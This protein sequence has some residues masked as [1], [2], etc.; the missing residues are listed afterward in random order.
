MTRSTL[1]ALLATLALAAPAPATEIHARG[2]L[3]MALSSGDEAR[4]TTHWTQ[5]D[6]PYDPYRVHLF[7]DA[8]V[9]PTLDLFVQTILHEGAMR[10]TADGAYAQWT[11]WPGRDAHLQAGKVPWPIGTWGAREYSDRN[12]L[13]GTP[14]MYQYHSALAWDVPASSV[15]Q[16]LANAGAGQY[17]LSYDGTSG[18]GMPVVDDRWWDVGVVALGA[19]RPLEYALGVLQGSPGW[20]VNGTDVTP[21]QTTLG[22]LGIVPVAGVRAGVSGAWGNWMPSWFADA[23]PAGRSLREYHEWTALADLELERGRWEL[24]GEG[25]LKGWETLRTGT[26]CV[27]GGYAEGRVALLA[28]G[29]LAARAEVMRFADVTGSAGITQPWDDGVDRIE[30]GGGYRLSRDVQLKATLQRD[31]TRPFRAPA[32][33]ADLLALAASIR[34]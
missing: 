14:L 10:V 19:Q 21:G 29:W 15:D 25:F 9:E 11:P 5:G 33:N 31:V 16:L 8:R 28:G 23:L 17:G 32:R 3:D 1:Y 13:I 4:E 20:P 26:L 27:R 12:P 24:R 18:S 34:F 30:A 6:S 22:R 2:L 7:L